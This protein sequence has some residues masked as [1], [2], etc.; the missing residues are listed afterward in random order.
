M[1]HIAYCQISAHPAYCGPSGNYCKEPIYS[2]NGAILNDVTRIDE[3]YKICRQIQDLYVDKF[4]FKIQQL[5]HPILILFAFTR[6]HIIF[7]SFL[8]TMHFAIL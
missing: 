2:S 7:R 4:R 1:L 8:S 6:S 3:V 5:L